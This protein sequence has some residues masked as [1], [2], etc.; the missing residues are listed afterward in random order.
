MQVS[1]SSNCLMQKALQTGKPEFDLDHDHLSAVM[2]KVRVHSYARKAI[3]GNFRN[4]F[5]SLEEGF[6]GHCSSKANAAHMLSSHSTIKR[7]PYPYSISVFWNKKKLLEVLALNADT[8][9]EEILDL[10]WNPHSSGYY[11]GRYCSRYFIQL[12]SGRLLHRALSGEITEQLHRQFLKTLT[13]V[14]HTPY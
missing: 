9:D 4:A 11:V 14:P 12:N 3:R 7:I 2:V 10:K 6:P 5:W 8:D 1:T 13:P